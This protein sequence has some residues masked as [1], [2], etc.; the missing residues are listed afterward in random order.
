MS[1]YDVNGNIITEEYYL[2]E[3]KKKFPSYYGL[4]LENAQIESIDEKNRKRVPPGDTSRLPKENLSVIF[5]KIYSAYYTSTLTVSGDTNKSYN[6][7]FSTVYVNDNAYGVYRFELLDL[8]DNSSYWYLTLNLSGHP[9]DTTW[10]VPDMPL[11]EITAEFIANECIK[12][13][14]P[15]TF[16]KAVSV[17]NKSGVSTADVSTLKGKVWIALGDS[18]TQYLAGAYTDGVTPSTSGKWAT[19]ASNLGMTLYSYGIASSTIRHSE[20]TGSDGFSC[21]PMVD[22]VDGL[23][24]DHADESD[25]VGLITFMGGINDPESW[26]GNLESTDK[27]T[28][29]GALHQIFYKLCNAFP[30]AHIV[31]ILQPTSAHGVASGDFDYIQGSIYPAQ[32]K[33]RAVKAV[34]EFY[35][36]KICDCC[37]DW[38]TPANPTH[39]LLIWQSDKLHLTDYGNQKLTEKLVKSLEEILV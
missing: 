37:F 21:V 17:A 13:S 8:P 36:L 25:N 18:Y 31:V 12:E 20:N 10:I 34:A 11:E 4:D 38:Y 9:N 29:Y 24:S 23:I 28:I 5:P 32:H 2:T 15:N 26:L 30:N 22:R 39:L 27:G 3:D 33:Q 35:G 1:I 14:V 6:S 16:I 19:L 7:S